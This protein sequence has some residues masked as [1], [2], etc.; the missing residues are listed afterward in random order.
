M[1]ITNMMMSNRAILNI[2]R[3]MGTA[4]RLSMQLST[5]RSIQSPSE[6]P[7]LAARVLKFRNSMREAEQHEQNAIQGLGWMTATENSMN[8]T[9]THLRTIRNLLNTGI[10]GEQGLEERTSIVNQ[11]NQLLQH[12]GT[13]MN[14][15]HAGRFVFSGF[16]TNHPPVFQTS[17]NQSFTIRQSFD[18]SDIKVVSA[19]HRTGATDQP[20]IVEGMRLLSLPF[21]GITPGSL[22][23][24]IPGAAGL[25]ADIIEISRDPATGFF[26]AG[27]FTPGPDDVHFIYETGELIL[28]ENVA[29]AM[30]DNAASITYTKT[31]FETGDLNPLIY[32][33]TIIASRI[34]VGGI[35][36]LGVTEA[37]DLLSS[38]LTNFAPPY[39]D[40]SHPA[41]PGF[42][43]ITDMHNWVLSVTLA[44]P[45]G[46]YPGDI[47]NL[48]PGSTMTH[49]ELLEEILTLNVA[50]LST[51]QL[52]AVGMLHSSVVGHEMRY[53]FSVNTRIAVNSVAPDVLTSQLHAE[54]S[55]LV[56]FVN[57]LE[58]SNRQ[59]LFDLMRTDPDNA[60]LTDEEVNLLVDEQLG[61]ESAAMS[62]ALGQRFNTMLGRVDM[63]IENHLRQESHLAGRIQ[64]IELI[65]ERLGYDILNFQDLLNENEG[66]NVPAVTQQWALAQVTLNASLMTGAR[67]IQMTLA[68]FLR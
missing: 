41:Y 28:G 38:L 47:D 6:N 26:P 36:E 16:R 23:F 44:P 9:T 3:N 52:G 45:A 33:D 62:L 21:G 43:T 58:T 34:D 27:T 32:F 50:N 63:H 65:E 56:R 49:R 67:I 59:M 39:I 19:V 51:E 25:P 57:S 12:I 42:A 5:L 30:Q 55:E 7:I 11:I 22:S 24:Q 68:D 2:H 35:L 53:E 4:D 48:I 10:T 46:L 20:A 64:R 1:R 40:P 37:N 60:G 29:T 13:E 54:L 17:N 15:S 18:F 66:V 31:G 61:R 14:A 8:S